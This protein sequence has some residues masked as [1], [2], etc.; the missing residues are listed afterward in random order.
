VADLDA[1]ERDWKADSMTNVAIGIRHGVSEGYIR[2]VAKN[3]NWQ[4]G[5]AV[6]ARPTPPSGVSAP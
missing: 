1:I 6:T 3:F 4:R 5:T 2:K